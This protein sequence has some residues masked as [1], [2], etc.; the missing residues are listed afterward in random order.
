MAEFCTFKKITFGI[1][2]T[3][4]A[5]SDTD[6]DTSNMFFEFFFDLFIMR[7]IANM[8]VEIMIR[9]IRMS[10][11]TSAAVVASITIPLPVRYLSLLKKNFI[12]KYKKTHGDFERFVMSILTYMYLR[13]KR[14]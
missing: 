7:T 10:T 11:T 5:M 1:T 4:I 6:R 13:T 8:L 9:T 2:N 3:A 12:S 14:C